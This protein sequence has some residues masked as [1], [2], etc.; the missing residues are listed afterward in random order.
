M[1]ERKKLSFMT[2]RAF[3]RCWHPPEVQNGAW[4]I[5]LKNYLFDLSVVRQAFVPVVQTSMPIWF[6]QG[7]IICAD[8]C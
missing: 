1:L 6:P 3:V 2:E 4:R 7:V 5:F 8:M